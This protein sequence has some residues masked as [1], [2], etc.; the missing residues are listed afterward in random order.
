MRCTLIK[1]LLSFGCRHYC[2]GYGIVPSV[3]VYPRW[4]VINLDD[5]E[6]ADDTVKVSYV[7][8]SLEKCIDVGNYLEEVL[9]EN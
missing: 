6:M 1:F 5:L 9:Y 8:D 2:L 4:L 7:S 3:S